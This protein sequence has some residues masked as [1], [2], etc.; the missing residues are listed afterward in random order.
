[1]RTLFMQEMIKRGVLFQGSFMPCFSHNEKD[2]AFFADA[3]ASSI[4]VYK[5]ALKEGYVKYLVGEPVKPVFRKY[6]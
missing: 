3:F 1:M 6:I 5:N 2:V 4:A